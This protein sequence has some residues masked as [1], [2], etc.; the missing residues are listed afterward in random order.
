MNCIGIRFKIGPLPCGNGVENDKGIA[1]IVAFTN[2]RNQISVDFSGNFIVKPENRLIAGICHLLNIFRYL[3]FG[4]KAAIRPFYGSQL[5]NT[6]KSGAILEVIR[7]VPTPQEVICAP[8][9]FRLSIRYS[10]KSLEA[11]ITAS[12]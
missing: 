1:R 9:L 4:N 2:E 6:A 7:F 5:V 10:S 3:D 11:E 8:W 12:V